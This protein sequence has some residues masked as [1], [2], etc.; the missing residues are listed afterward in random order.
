MYSYVC[1]YTDTQYIIIV[2]D[3]LQLQFDFYRD[4]QIN[5]KRQKIWIICELDGD[6]SNAFFT[7]SNYKPSIE[8]RAVWTTS[9]SVAR[10][11]ES[12]RKVK[13]KCYRFYLQIFTRSWIIDIFFL[14]FLSLYFPFFFSFLLNF[15]FY[16]C[17]CSFFCSFACFLSLWNQEPE[18]S[19]D[20]G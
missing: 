2:A 20:A 11:A 3:G 9:Q 4:L 14:R 16:S 15:L 10:Y 13:Q 7:T 8:S 12:Y 6:Q 5:V 1:I 17:F 19:I 18:E